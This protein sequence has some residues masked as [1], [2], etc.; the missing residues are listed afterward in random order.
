VHQLQVRGLWATHLLVPDPARLWALS[1]GP[2]L[3]VGAQ[4][5]CW[6]MV[7]AFAL[8]TASAW[9]IRADWYDLLRQHGFE[10]PVLSLAVG[11]AILHLAWVL[12]AVLVVLGLAD[13]SLRHR[14]F[15]AMLRVTPQEH[16]E[17]QR[18]MEGDPATRA[19]RRKVARTLRFDDPD[20]LVG[21][22]LVLNGSGGLTVVLAGGPPPRRVTVRTAARG[23]AGLRLRR[24]AEASQ[25]PQ[26]GAPDLAR[27][28]VH[29]LAAGSPASGELIAEL[30][31]IWSAG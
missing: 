27:C 13:L 14:R 23:S 20:L 7:K 8:V 24:S 21:A 26:V 22:S 30:A 1:A 5:S 2:G 15:E 11:R 28:L 3:V 17:D 31:A 6:S 16:R 10:G 29:R 12:S 25:I 18:V 9:V 19:Q 4:R